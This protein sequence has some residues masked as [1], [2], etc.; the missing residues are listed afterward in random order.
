KPSCP[1]SYNRAR[2]RYLLEHPGAVAVVMM[3]LPIVVERSRFDNGDGGVEPGEAPHLSASAGPYDRAIGE[4]AVRSAMRA[5]IGRLLDRGLKVVLVYPVPEM[6]WHIPH[7]LLE[8]SRD[9]PAG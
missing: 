8:L 1:E 6:G 7:K 9:R 5:T 4:A 2:M 3:R